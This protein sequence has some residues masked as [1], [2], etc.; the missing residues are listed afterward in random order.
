MERLPSQ[1]RI[2]G[3]R[4]KNQNNGQRR[5]SYGC[6]EETGAARG[7]NRWEIPKGKEKSLIHHDS[8][9]NLTHWKPN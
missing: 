8:L 9:G 1:L 5:K 6:K 3:P 4:T 7:N 2:E